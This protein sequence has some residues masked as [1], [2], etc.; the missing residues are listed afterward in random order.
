MDVVVHEDATVDDFIDVLEEMGT[1]PRKYVKCLYVYNK[2]DMLSIDLVD[3]LARQPY[4][5]VISVNKKLNLDGLLARIW[6]EL[7]LVRVYT[8]KKG[9]FPDFKDPLVMTQQRG[10]KTPSVENAVGMLHKS[11]LEEFKAAMVWGSSVRS[12]P[13]V[14]GSKHEL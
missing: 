8:K 1:A 6:Q 12:S 7:E 5:V 11:I 10:S 13:Q 9:M 4:S 2:I 3:A 14:C